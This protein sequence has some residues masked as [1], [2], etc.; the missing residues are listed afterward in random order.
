MNRQKIEL[1][2]VEHDVDF[3]LYWSLY[4]KFMDEVF[5]N[6]EIGHISGSDYLKQFNSNEN[7]VYMHKLFGREIDTAFPVIFIIN[8]E[9]VGFTTYCTYHS[10]DGKCLIVDYYILPEYRDSGLG[11][12]FF[13]RVKEAEINKGAKFFELNVSNRRNM[14]FWSNNGFKLT[15]VDEFGSVSMT[16]NKSNVF[17]SEINEENWI[18]A[19]NLKVHDWQKNYIGSSLGIIARGY[20]FRK[21]NAKV[22]G[23]EFC[24]DLIGLIMI[25]DIEEEPKCYEIQ[26]FFIDCRFQDKGYGYVSLKLIIDYMYIERKYETIEI[27]VKRED[28]KAINL[29]KKIGFIKTDYIDINSPDSINM[30]FYFEDM[31]KMFSEKKRSLMNDN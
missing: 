23:I 3:K 17:L 10:E 24:G 18:E 14:N 16:T 9:V 5:E 19:V 1:K 20:V 30:L 6:E 28:T 2:Y 25:R 21:S 11:S 7:K 26:Q 31:D 29:Y 15:G 27:S 22:F 8:S 12:M 13:E 4:D